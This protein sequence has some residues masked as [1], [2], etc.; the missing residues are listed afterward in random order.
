[1]AANS[2]LYTSRC[3]TVPI[4]VIAASQK[5]AFVD[6]MLRR[7]P[8]D[9]AELFMHEHTDGNPNAENYRLQP[10]VSADIRGEDPQQILDEIGTF[11]DTDEYG[12]TI[13]KMCFVGDAVIDTVDW[14]EAVNVARNSE[15]VRQVVNYLF[16]SL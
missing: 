1:V 4:I 16:D 12:A 14:S 11:A 7:L 15:E 13:S 10:F 5:E 2:A 8:I 3:Q 6:A 9:D